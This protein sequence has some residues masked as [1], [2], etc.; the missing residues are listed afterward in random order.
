MQQKYYYTYN[1]TTKRLTI[2]PR[3]LTIGG[4]VI[5]NP[6]ADQ[7]AEIGAYPV[8]ATA[9]EIVKGKVAIIDGYT[10]DGDAWRPIYAYVDAPPR[11]FSKLKLYAALASANLWDPLMAWLAEQTYNGMNAKVAFE[12][13]QDLT[14]D[15]PL[16][17]QWLA[18]VKAALNVG[19][20]QA[21]AILAAAVAD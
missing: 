3:T 15:H 9:P 19:D 13:A 20:E 10:R 6:T 12:L 21:E 1:V 14:E 4:H 7:Y 16:F 18:A 2:A 17:A 11:T 5:A 8:A